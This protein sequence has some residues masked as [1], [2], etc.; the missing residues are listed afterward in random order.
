MSDSKMVCIRFV[1]RDGQGLQVMMVE[2]EAKAL[3]TMLVDKVQARLPVGATK[4]V[5]ESSALGFWA[6]NLADI[7]AFH[8]VEPPGKEAYGRVPPPASASGIGSSPFI[9]GNR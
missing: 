6:V 7:Q 9:P 2:T 5:G 8:T 1:L 3:H 4:M